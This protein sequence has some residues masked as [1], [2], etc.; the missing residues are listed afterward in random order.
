[1]IEVIGVNLIDTLEKSTFERLMS[2]TS[3]EKCERI[4]R[5]HIYED[6]LR[7]LIGD[8][9]IRYMLCQRLKI[10]SQKLKFEVNEF[11]KPFLIN[12]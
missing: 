9:L 11:G 8:I 10:K 5:F 12:Y 1:M 6:A 3:D 7:T 2:Y 4:K